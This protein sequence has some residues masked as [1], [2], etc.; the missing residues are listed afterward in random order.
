MQNLC[1]QVI[2]KIWICHFPFILPNNRSHVKYG[3]K[4]GNF[5]FH[6]C[7]VIYVYCCRWDVQGNGS[8]RD[9]PHLFHEYIYFSGIKSTIYYDNRDMKAR[10]HS[11]GIKVGG[12]V[13]NHV[14][15]GITDSLQQCM[16][17]HTV[18]W[19]MVAM[20]HWRN[21]LA[22]RFHQALSMQQNH[23]LFTLILG[24]NRLYLIGSCFCPTNVI[25]NLSDIMLVSRW[26]LFQGEF[27]DKGMNWTKPWYRTKAGSRTSHRWPTSAQRRPPAVEGWRLKYVY[28]TSS[29]AIREDSILENIGLDL[30]LDPGWAGWI[31]FSGNAA[32]IVAPAAAMMISPECWQITKINCSMLLS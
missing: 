1:Q 16:L 22:G 8:V 14:I 15:E 5:R 31:S 17:R 28:L 11:C 29:R 3:F 9:T 27:R 32:K 21:F 12:L 18:Q 30:W 23:S 20:W 24:V 13:L 7:N 25:T 10:I 2:K 26:R 4:I 6:I 19:D